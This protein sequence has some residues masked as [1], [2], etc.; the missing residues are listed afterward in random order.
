MTTARQI[1][2]A[3][4]TE[5]EI[6]D[7]L[8]Q[9]LTCAL[10][11]LNDDGSIHLTYLLFLFEDERFL[12]ETASTTR[13]ARNVAARPT[14]SILVQGRAASGRSLMVEAEGTARIALASEAHAI[15]HR[16]RAKYVVPDALQELD[17][18]WGTFDDVS[19]EVTPTRWRSWTGTALAETTAAAMGRPYG[20]IWLDD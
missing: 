7:V 15:I 17:A 6:A 1:Y 18:V 16:I 13:K 20:E 10:G 11:T 12:L 5:E 19:I 9:R 2:R 3:H 8:G 14:A 4:P